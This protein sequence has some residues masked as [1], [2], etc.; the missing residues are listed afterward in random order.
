MRKLFITL[1][2]M[3]LMYLGI[4]VCFK[5]FTKSY[6]TIYQLNNIEVKETIVN[7][8]N[9]YYNFE[10]KTP[11]NTFYLA[12][13]KN[14]NK[15]SNIIE[16]IKIF[17]NNKYE[18]ILP[19]FE[20]KTIISDIKCISNGVIKDY[21]LLKGNGELDKFANEIEEYKML[22]TE[23]E[24][25]NKDT[26]TV[27]KNNLVDKH[28]IAINS[29][30]GLYTINTNNVNTI[31]DTKLFA[32]DVYKRT[33]SLYSKDIYLVADY[34]QKFDFTVFKLVNVKDAEGSKIT[35]KY[36]ISFDSFIQGV[37]DDNVYIID[38]NSKMQYKVDIDNKIVENITNGTKA[39][40][41]ENGEFTELEINQI[42]NQKL[43]F[44]ETNEVINNYTEF[45][46]Y[47]NYYYFYKRVNGGYEIYRTIDKKQFTY[48]FTAQDINEVI[49]AKD[50]VYYIDGNKIKYYN[51]TT[52]IKTVLEN[53]EFTFNDNIKFYVYSK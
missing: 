52:G 19:I 26:L 33:I 29:Y 20:D 53:T 25:I 50:Y 13:Y 44:K 4:Q 12:T 31:Y 38:S 5:M 39:T 34:D 11:N 18:C 24:I 22:A 7:D 8:S 27:Y 49:C 32:S 15:K 6:V 42:I 43:K 21:Q 23:T 1:L 46:K 36:N 37:V 30:K 3:F 51:D 10:I 9:D 40:H 2:I 47:Q 35:S 14:F 48:L 28:F 41:Y 17:N 16:D 45:N